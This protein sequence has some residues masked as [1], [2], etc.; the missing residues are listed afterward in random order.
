MSL[1]IGQFEEI[2]N[3]HPDVKVNFAPHDSGSWR[4]SYGEACIFVNMEGESYLE[5][6]IPFIEQLRTGSHFGYKGGEYTYNEDTPLNFETDS[7]VWSDNE[8]FEQLLSENPAFAELL[9]EI[10]V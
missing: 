8:T 3:L 5:E 1:T 9:E 4:G 2:C 7:W 10:G 6:C